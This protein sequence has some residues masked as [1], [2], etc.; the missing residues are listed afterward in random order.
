MNKFVYRVE[1]Y[2]ENELT[3]RTVGIF[4]DQL[5]AESAANLSFQQLTGPGDVVVIQHELN[6][7]SGPDEQPYVIFSKQKTE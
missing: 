4:T 1:V 2:D 6:Q 3:I 5:D 7:R